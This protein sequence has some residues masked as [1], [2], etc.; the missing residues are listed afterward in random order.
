MHTKEILCILAGGGAIVEADVSK[1]ESVQLV[2][3]TLPFFPHLLLI[4]IL[5]ATFMHNSTYS[6]AQTTL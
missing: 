4:R 5:L 1:L 2:V 3:V 6:V